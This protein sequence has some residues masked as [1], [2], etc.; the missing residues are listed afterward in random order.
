MQEVFGVGPCLRDACNA[1]DLSDLFVSGAI[2]SGIVSP[3]INF[4]VQNTS[5][6]Y[7]GSTPVSVCITPAT[8][9]PAT[10]TVRILDASTT[11]LA[12]LPL[13]GNS[14]ANWY[15]NP[16]LSAGTHSLSATYSGDSNNPDG[17]SAPITVTVSPTPS[18]LQA[19]CGNAGFVYSGNYNC[20]VNVGSEVGGATGAI[21]YTF[22]GGAPVTLHL[23]NGSAQFSLIAPTAGSHAVVIGYAQQGNFAAAGP[24]TESFTVAPATTQIW[25]SPSNWYPGAGSSLTLSASVTSY[26]AAAP[27]GGTVTFYA[28]GASIGTIPVSSTG[29][30]S[31]S[32]PSLAAGYYSFNAQF[33]GL[34]PDYDAAGSNY[35]TIQAH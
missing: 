28:N 13:Q 17:T 18:Y 22:D 30:A 31:V 26:S 12:I 9:A 5:L 2:P 20:N 6:V 32:I 10:G 16:P 11:I 14:C 3:A 4:Q 25:L 35:L 21:T 19:S 23:N 33:G 1:T 8:S 34:A 7:P 29:Q 15:V 24:A 27:T